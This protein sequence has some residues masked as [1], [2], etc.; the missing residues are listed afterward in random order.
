MQTL[1]KKPTKI[2]SGT[3]RLI[4][5]K[6]PCRKDCWSCDWFNVKG[7]KVTCHKKKS[8]FIKSC[9]VGVKSVF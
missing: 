1:I 6:L 4:I 9:P 2:F 5:S 7:A 8:I 3:K